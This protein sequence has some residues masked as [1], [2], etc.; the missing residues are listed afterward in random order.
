[1]KEATST[2]V[3]TT[4]A[5][6]IERPLSAKELAPILGLHVVTILRWA[7]EGRIPCRRLSARKIVFLSTEVNKWL[8]SNYAG[9]A[10]HAA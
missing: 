9:D 2:A 6:P 10:V 5:T 8:S 4:A 3:P 7:K 1:M